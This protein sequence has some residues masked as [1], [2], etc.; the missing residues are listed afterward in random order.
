LDKCILLCRPETIGKNDS[1]MVFIYDIVKCRSIFNCFK[2]YW[3]W[4][5][6]LFWWNFILVL[7]V[8]KINFNEYPLFN[9]MCTNFVT[10]FWWYT[11]DEIII[12]VCQPYQMLHSSCDISDVG[13]WNA[14]IFMS[15]L[16]FIVVQNNTILYIDVY[17]QIT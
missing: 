11:S 8:E 9:K 14:E 10:F 6:N 1:K 15:R 7:I 5:T 17:I 13:N 16:V 2:C 3:L 12:L 4:F